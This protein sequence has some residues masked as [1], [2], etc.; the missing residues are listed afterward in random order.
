MEL[1]YIMILKKKVNHIYFKMNR[2]Q[3]IFNVKNNKNM[4]KIYIIM[5]I[6]KEINK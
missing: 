4:I 2:F 1:N 3:M 5:V 6:Y